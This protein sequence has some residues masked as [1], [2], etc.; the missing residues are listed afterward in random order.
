MLREWQYRL[1]EPR[2]RQL[3]WQL[4]QEARLPGERNSTSSRLY[5]G[6]YAV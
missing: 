4:E 3:T 2:P 6:H 5:R 1:Q